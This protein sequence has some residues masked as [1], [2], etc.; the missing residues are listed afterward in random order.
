MVML[1]ALNIIIIFFVAAHAPLFFCVDICASKNEGILKIRILGLFEV[2]VDLYAKIAKLINK[3]KDK[4]SVSA[5]PSKKRKNNFISAIKK[6]AINRIIDSFTR[7]TRCR[8]GQ[9]KVCIIPNAQSVIISAVV[10]C[11]YRCVTKIIP[12]VM[13]SQ[14]SSKILTQSKENW[15]FCY[16]GIF[17]VS[18]ADIICGL[19][20]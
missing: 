9:L 7:R 6:K 17:L 15:R 2:D 1:I 4:S 5:F 16:T 10:L 11:L 13:S 14:T 19:F 12:I 18:A 8:C 20:N 3:L